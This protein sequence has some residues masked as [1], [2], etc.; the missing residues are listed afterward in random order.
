MM[1][2]NFILKI[3]SSCL[4]QLLSNLLVHVNPFMLAL[5]L[6][7]GDKL[8]KIV[9]IL[10]IKWV[11]LFLNVICSVICLLDHCFPLCYL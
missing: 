2:V 3:L 11:R 9:H 5:F 6:S 10:V 7:Y 1:H 4:L 8:V